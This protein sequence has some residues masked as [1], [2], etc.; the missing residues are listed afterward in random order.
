[1]G[2]TTPRG[3]VTGH[4]A[5]LDGLRGVAV[6]AVVLS[7]AVGSRAETLAIGVDVFFVISGFLITSILM[8]ELAGTGGIDLRRF[9]R[10]RM[11]R[12]YPAL[13][14][15]AV[16]TAVVFAFARLD[17]WRETAIAVPVSLTYLSALPS[18]LGGDLGW[19]GHTWSLSVEEAFYLVWPVLL[20]GMHRLG[21]PLRR[22]VAA[23]FGASLA[24]HVVLAQVASGDWIYHAPDAR[25]VQIL[26]GAAVAVAIDPT[27]RAVSRRLDVGAVAGTAVLGA[28]VLG[29]VPSE[30][31]QLLVVAAACVP[32]LVWAFRR[33]DVR[34]LSNAPTQW[35]G[36]RSY[37]IYLVHLPLLGLHLDSWPTPVR[38]GVRLAAIG[39]SLLAADLLYRHWE[40]PMRQRF[41]ERRPR[42]GSVDLEAVDPATVTPSAHP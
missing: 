12:L 42:P 40:R 36:V 19:L 13:V 37:S 9:Y 39:A 16:V 15:V 31:L 27:V 2:R 11:A 22:T 26:T 28:V 21:V 18:S 34:L 41:A 17:L 20:L 7:H 33:P 23:A 6:V 1:M 10:R 25:A 32:L 14:L 24:W 3:P 38:L 4:V 5:S 30:Q 35:V 29:A 8:T